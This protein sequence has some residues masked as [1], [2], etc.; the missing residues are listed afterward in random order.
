M[1]WLIILSNSFLNN[2]TYHFDAP[3]RSFSLSLSSIWNIYWMLK[4]N[5]EKNL[6]YYRKKVTAL[7]KS[8]CQVSKPKYMKKGFDCKKNRVCFE[9]AHTEKSCLN[10]NRICLHKKRFFQNKSKPFFLC[11]CKEN[12]RKEKLFYQ[13]TFKG[14]R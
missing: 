10:K 4:L 11:T 14:L 9:T 12:K 13:P 7:S 6:N 8:R 5:L 2:H 1:P 3:A